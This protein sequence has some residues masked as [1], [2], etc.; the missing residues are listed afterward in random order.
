MGESVE[1][2]S[3]SPGDITQLLGDFASGDSAAAEKLAS[4][5]YGELRRIARLYF[6][7][8][9]AAHTLQ[10]TAL[11]NE[12]FLRLL[13]GKR[14]SIANR[15]H[16]FAI[17]AKSMRRVLIDHAR[18]KNS[19]RRG[20]GEAP[21]ALEEELIY[22]DEKSDQL[23]ALDDALTTL[24]KFDPRQAYIVELKFFCGMTYEEMATALSIS[25][26]TV[27]RDWG[28]AKAWLRIEMEP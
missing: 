15:A 11:V 26:M 20:C 16:F 6:R 13:A 28:L 9:R 19:A 18:Q 8:E 23:I 27:R 14:P 24:E 22:S 4:L 2:V 25:E 3:D 7:R 1:P 21:L 12:A 10:P 5:V 17:A